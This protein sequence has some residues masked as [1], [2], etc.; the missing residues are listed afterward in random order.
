[1]SYTVVL[2]S[3]FNRQKSK[4]SE[5]MG[6][7]ASLQTNGHWESLR[8]AAKKLQTGAIRDSARNDSERL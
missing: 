2:G 5:S 8:K 3:H 7:R 1:M 4:K 6:K